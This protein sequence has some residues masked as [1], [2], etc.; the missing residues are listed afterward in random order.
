MKPA[1][2]ADAYRM[3]VR[4]ATANRRLAVTRHQT[5]VRLVA[6]RASVPSTHSYP[7]PPS[8]STPSSA[9]THSSASRAIAR[10]ATAVSVPQGATDYESR[11]E[12]AI[13]IGS[14]RATPGASMVLAFP[15]AAPTSN[16]L[17]ARWGST[18]FGSGETV[19]RI[20]LSLRMSCHAHLGR[21]LPTV[22]GNGVYQCSRAV[23][24]D[25]G[26]VAVAR[27]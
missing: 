8:H 17:P 18:V 23:E 27:E 26:V 22:L 20:N 25:V 13:A 12:L 7:N 3:V 11:S 24:R 16:G 9:R 19:S 10:M 21:P 2:P 4:D 14:R 15:T 5:P 1:G 6:D